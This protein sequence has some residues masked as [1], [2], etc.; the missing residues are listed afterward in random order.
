MITQTSKVGADCE[1]ICGKCGDV[2]HVVVAKVGERVAKVQC[3]QCGA[4][5][6]HRPPAGSAEAKKSAPGTRVRAAGAGKLPKGEKASRTPREKPVL[7]PDPLKPIRAY[8]ATDAFI[9]GDTIKHVTF[10]IGVAE[11]IPEPGKILISFADA[12]RLLVMAKPNDLVA[13]P[14]RRTSGGSGSPT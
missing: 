11:V 5:H 6:R 2:W 4:V 8:R 3:K 13:L 14:A 12:R 10:G 1:S 7:V 9:V